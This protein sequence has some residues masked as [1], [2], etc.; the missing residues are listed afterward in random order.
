MVSKLKEKKEVLSFNTEKYEKQREKSAESASSLAIP[1]LIL[2]IQLKLKSDC[3]LVLSFAP[4]KRQHSN[5]SFIISKWWAIYIINSDN[6]SK[7][8]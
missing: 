3:I 2:T 4:T 7:P 1:L 8:K 5:V 6:K